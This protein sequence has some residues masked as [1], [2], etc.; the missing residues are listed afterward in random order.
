MGNDKTILEE[1][2]SSGGGELEVR[3]GSG[4]TRLGF[5]LPAPEKGQD[6]SSPYLGAA[7]AV[8]VEIEGKVEQLQIVGNCPEYLESEIGAQRRRKHD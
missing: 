2:I 6:E 8:N 7:E 1:R 5:S 4:F 3:Q